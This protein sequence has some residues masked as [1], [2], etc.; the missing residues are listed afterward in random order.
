MRGTCQVR[1]HNFKQTPIRRWSCLTVL[2]FGDTFSNDCLDC[3]IGKHV[4]DMVTNET[5]EDYM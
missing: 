5:D 4:F 2:V 1:G 3:L